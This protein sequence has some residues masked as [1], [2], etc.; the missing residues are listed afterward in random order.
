MSTSAHRG[1]S[2]LTIAGWNRRAAH[3]LWDRRIGRAA[4][5]ELAALRLPAYRALAGFVLL[6]VV[7]GAALVVLPARWPV[8]QIVAAL[9]VLAVLLVGIGTRPM[10]RA[11]RAVRDAVA[12]DGANVRGAAPLNDGLAFDRWVRRNDLDERLQQADVAALLR[13][14]R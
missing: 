5:E 6:L 13:S 1:P 4:A 9:L 3:A 14:T 10:R 7:A 12:G 11:G 2:P 8:L